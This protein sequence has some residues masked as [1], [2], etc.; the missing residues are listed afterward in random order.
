V[1]DAVIV[2]RKLTL[3]REHVE[4]VRRRRPSTTGEYLADADLQDASAMSLF[5]AIQQALDIAMHIA[6]DEGWGVP[7]SYAEGFDLL[8]Q[9]GV[10][11]ASL[12]QKLGR[13]SALRNRIAHGYAALEADRLYRETPDGLDALERFATAV[14]NH[15]GQ[16]D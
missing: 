1:T 7:A 13:V 3:L 9:N 2:L 10:V 16:A 12:A 6:A 8:A 5:V 4:R 11:D 15:L 14:A